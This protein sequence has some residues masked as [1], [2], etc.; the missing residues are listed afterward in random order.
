VLSLHGRTALVCS[1]LT[2]KAIEC[3]SASVRWA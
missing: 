1:D 2:Y 3:R